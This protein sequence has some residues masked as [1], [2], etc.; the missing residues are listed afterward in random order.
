MTSTLDRRIAF[1]IAALTLGVLLGASAAPSPLYPVYQQAWGFS[2]ITLPLVFAVYVFALLGALL[3][4]GS[5]SDHVGRRPVIIAALLLLAVAMVLFRVA[6]GVG[7]L[8]AARIVQGIAV[9]AATGTLSA[10]L[11]DLQPSQRVGTNVTSATPAVGMAFGAVLSGGLVEYAPEPRHLVYEVFLVLALAL[12]VVMWFQPEAVRDQPRS[13]RALLASLRPSAGVP[14]SMR[15]LFLAQVPAIAATWSLGGLYLSLGASVVGRELHVAN[16]LLAGLV[17]AAMFGA[18]GVAVLVNGALP[19]RVRRSAGFA[20]LGAGIALSVVGALV[21]SLTT[22][23]L[24]SAVAG[25]GFGWTFQNVMGAIAAATPATERGRVFA[26]TFVVSYSAFSIP[27]L[28]AGFAVQEYGLRPTLVGYGAFELLL[29][30]GAAAG[31][32]RTSRGPAA[33]VVPAGRDR[34]P[35]AEG[36]CEQTV[37]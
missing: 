10:S 7:G 14:R 8:V 15:G 2:S 12:V 30:L 4:I 3:T 22:Y 11:A 5:V 18:G 23:L 36:A 17:L 13:W 28:V 19:E 31:S 20:A 29:V 32:T 21:G 16:H 27:A 25:L 9:G 24:A 34:C 1:A 35:V 37:G 33:T 26:T 6:D